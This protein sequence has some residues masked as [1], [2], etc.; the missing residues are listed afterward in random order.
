M[1]RAVALLTLVL[2]IAPAALGLQRVTAQDQKR[3]AK[4]ESARKDAK[5]APAVTPER[6]AAVNAFVA[7]HHPELGELLKHLKGIKNQKQ[8]ERAIRDLYAVSEKLAGL[9]KSDS[10]RYELEL[11]AWKVKSRIQLLSARLTMG[12]NEDLKYQ[13][14]QA[15]AE[16]YDLRREV[17]SLEKNRLHE[18]VQK[19]E[20]DLIDYD[21]RREAALDK[22]FQ[23]LTSTMPKGRP[24]AKNK[25][26][27]PV[28]PKSTTG[29]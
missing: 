8:Y 4:K 29:S 5:E 21:S 7:E 15:L 28:R 17:L 18:R 9:Q 6:E 10:G 20:K 13:L 14:K 25:T 26:D 11:K 23:Q 12:D 16:Q 2:T 22:Q 19:L 24:G 3:P 1:L 27:K